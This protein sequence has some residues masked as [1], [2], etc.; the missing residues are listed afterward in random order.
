MLD[1]FIKSSSELSIR[2]YLHSY[3]NTND[4]N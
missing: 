4:W 2:R 1:N 3:S